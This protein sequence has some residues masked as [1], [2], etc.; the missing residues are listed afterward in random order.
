MK[1]VNKLAAAVAVALSAGLVSPANATLATNN[2]TP[3]EVSSV[4][5]GDTLLFPLFWGY[6]ENYF[7]IS[8]ASAQWIQ[9]HLRFRGAAWSGELLD[10]DI[11]LSPGDVFVFRLADVDGDGYW[12]VDQSLDVKNFQYTGL[13]QGCSPEHG[14]QGREKCMDQFTT[15]I[16][17]VTRDAQGNEIPPITTPIIEH[18]RHM[19]YVEFI[20]EATLLGGMTKSIMADLVNLA[21]MPYQRRVG[22]SRG[23]S[24]W[25]WAAAAWSCPGSTAAWCAN[26]TPSLGDVPNELSGTA[27]INMPGQSH[28]LAMN[29]ESIV[30]FRTASFPHRID[31]YPLNNA[32]ILHHE[33]AGLGDGDYFYRYPGDSR[34]DEGLVSFNNTWG[35]TLA[36]G[37][38]YDLIGLRYATPGTSSDD[39]D[40]YH[41]AVGGAAMPNSIGEVEEAFRQL[42]TTP[43]LNL[44]GAN[45]GSAGQRFTSFYFDDAVFDKSGASNAALHSWY[46]AWFPTKFYYGE[47]QQYHS[48]PPSVVRRYVYNTTGALLGENG[49]LQAAVAHLLSI[50]KAL[51]VEVWDTD[52]NTV[53]ETCVVSPCLT[54]PGVIR[55]T[56]ELNIFDIDTLKNVFKS[57]TT[58]QGWKEGRVV[59]SA[60]PVN[61]GPN[62][63]NWPG[64]PSP[65]QMPNLK[66]FPGMIYAFELATGGNLSNWRAWHR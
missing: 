17:P 59:L 27:F 38:D 39:W 10:M 57:T 55:L 36:D 13:E 3:M 18:H 1:H 30:N 66:S 25:A 20:G 35:P 34:N 16:P 63:N 12:E 65:M 40:S 46:F 62:S 37:D 4:K 23:T 29:A 31:N 19:G 43:A 61:A 5:R 64:M 51:S 28:G 49:Y 44:V 9:G 11:I 45:P 6:G 32:A 2:Y 26:V 41:V 58:H 14:G 48:Y 54:T 52:E 21:G 53:G 56:H 15:L 60:F 22:N 50:D 8:N 33:N 42:S 24:T 7:T 47:D